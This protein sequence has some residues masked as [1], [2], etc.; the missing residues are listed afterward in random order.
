MGDLLLHRGD[1]QLLIG[2]K[3]VYLQRQELV[4]LELFAQHEGEV[5]SI[6]T[7]AC[8]LSRNG[9]PLSREAVAVQ[10]HRLRA[11]LRASTVRIETLRGQGYRLEALERITPSAP[12]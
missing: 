1:P 3:T 7:L 6:Q 12:L 8:H 10:V 2:D 11:R 9:R 4:L 5:L